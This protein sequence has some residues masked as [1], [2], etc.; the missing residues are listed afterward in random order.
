MYVRCLDCDW[1]QDDFYSK[2]GYNPTK[3]IGD[4]VE[5]FF[6]GKVKKDIIVKA[7]REYANDVENMKWMTYEEFKNDNNK[8]CPKCGSN[9]FRTD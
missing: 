1:E 7:L 8:T 5:M 4:W 2:N 3:K 6:D 9:N